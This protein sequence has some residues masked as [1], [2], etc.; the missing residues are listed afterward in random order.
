MYLSIRQV[1]FFHPKTKHG[2][3]PLIRHCHAGMKPEQKL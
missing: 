2:V 3:V 1:F